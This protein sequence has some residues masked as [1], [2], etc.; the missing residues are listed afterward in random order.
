[1][2]AF[3]GAMT[4]GRTMSQDPPEDTPGWTGE[5]QG[6]GSGRPGWPQADP[7][8]RAPQAGPSG[9]PAAG[10]P[11]PP[12]PQAGPPQRGQQ[13]P[14][15]GQ[16]PQYG[17]PQYGQPQYG[18]PQYGQPQYGQPQYGQPQYGQPQY[19]QPQYGQP[20]YGQ[21]Q[22]GQPQYGQQQPQ[23]GPPQNGPQQPQ[24]GPP[25]YGSQYAPPP[26][27]AYQQAGYQQPGYQAVPGVPGPGAPA[28][29]GQPSQSDDRTWAMMSY[30]LVFVCGILAPL[31]VYLV[32]KD[33]S[34]FVRYHAAQG[35]NLALTSAIYSISLLVLALLAGAV[36]HG[37]GFLLILLYIPLG[38]TILVYLIMAAVAANRFEMYQIPNW[39]CFPLVH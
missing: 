9:P 11:Q 13:Q 6:G 30:L 24:Y 29:Y 25:Q 14:Q 27:A 38:I 15:Y 36:S 39:A 12:R 2:W 5:A 4:G 20:Q 8:G 23:Y 7:H 10:S 37:L 28:Y 3:L 19:G 26:G 16:A 17:Q 1:M 18:Q 34:P 33:Q 22:H 31:T 21:P 35:I 32:K